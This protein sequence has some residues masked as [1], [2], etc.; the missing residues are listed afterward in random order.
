LRS[1]H[2]ISPQ[3]SGIH[4]EQENDNDIKLAIKPSTVIITEETEQ[5]ENTVEQQ[6]PD[7][8]VIP[9]PPFPKIIMIEKPVVYPNFDI[10]R[11]LKNLCVKI[12][13]LQ[14]LQDIPIYAKT[15]KELCGKKPKRKTKNPS[16][17]HVVGTLSDLILGK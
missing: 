6:N 15:I 12:P 9:P 17:V 4:Q 1:R 2:V 11:E 10:V 13:L 14:A 5:G 7:K 3:E 16:T 8:D